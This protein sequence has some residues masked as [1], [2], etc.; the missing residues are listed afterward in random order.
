MNEN[1]L[2]AVMI[3]VFC[4]TISLKVRTVV[5]CGSYSR[6]SFALRCVVPLFSVGERLR[7]ASNRFR[8]D[9]RSFRYRTQPTWTLHTSV[10]NVRWPPQN[11]SASIS[12]VTTVALK[13]SVA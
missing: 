7:P 12:G 10:S 11:G 3:S 9:V 13:V 6:Q 8:R 5:Q 4:K 2:E 1:P